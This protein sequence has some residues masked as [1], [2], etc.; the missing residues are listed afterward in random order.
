MN[1]FDRLK[2]MYDEWEKDNK[3]DLALK[4][5]INYLLTRNDL[6]NKFLNEEKTVDG[7]YKFIQSKGKRHSLE[8]W[9]FITNEVVL[10]WAVMYFSLP[11]NFFRINKTTQKKETKKT[12]SKQENPKNN[13]VSL[14]KVKKEIENK[15]EVSQL[16]LFG[17]VAQ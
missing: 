8:G 1:G 16:S 14:D 11:D 17:G 13:I 9:C 6:E 15:K 10:A 4:E 2:N 5:V 3:E 7:L 12:T